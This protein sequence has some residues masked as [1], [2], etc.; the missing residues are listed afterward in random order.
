MRMFSRAE[1]DKLLDLLE[2]HRLIGRPRQ[3]G[4]AIGMNPK[5]VARAV[6]RVRK[7]DI[8]HDPDAAAWWAAH[9][10]LGKRGRIPK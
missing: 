8:D 2:Q 10:N 1:D 4:R 5:D 6:E 3:I 9:H 7:A